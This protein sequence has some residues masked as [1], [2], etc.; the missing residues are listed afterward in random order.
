MST[1][2]RNIEQKAMGWGE[3]AAMV[4]TDSRKKV[5][6]QVYLSIVIDGR[7]RKRNNGKISKEGENGQ[8][9]KENRI[10]R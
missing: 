9:K 3:V 2:K 1:E 4:R 8:V 5:C 6:H 10:K 7:L